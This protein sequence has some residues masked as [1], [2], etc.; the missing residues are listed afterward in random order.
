VTLEYLGTLEQHEAALRYEVEKLDKL[1]EELRALIEPTK[2]RLSLL[3]HRHTF[4]LRAL[5]AVRE[6]REAEGATESDGIPF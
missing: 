3:D 4:L 1:R 6:A 5:V 2:K